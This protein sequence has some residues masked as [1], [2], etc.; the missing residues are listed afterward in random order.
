MI[1]I[2]NCKNITMALS[3]YIQMQTKVLGCLYIITLVL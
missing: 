3:A 1:G 2:Y